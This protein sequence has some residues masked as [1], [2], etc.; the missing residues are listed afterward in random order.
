MRLP[1]P[2]ARS[3][4]FA[5]VCAPGR[6]FPAFTYQ[7]TVGEYYVMNCFD[8]RSALKSLWCPLAL[9]ALLLVPPAHAQKPNILTWGENMSS[10]KTTLGVTQMRESCT[11]APSECEPYLEN[12]GAE[13]SSAGYYYVSF[14]MDPSTSI[15]YA[16]DWSKLSLTYKHMVEIDFDD[17][18]GKLED[19]EIANPDS[20]MASVLAATKKYN[21][22]LAFGVTLYED[23]LLSTSYSYPTLIKLSATTRAK[24]GYVHLFIHYRENA[25]NWS[26]YVSQAK[27]LFPNAKIIA[28]AYPY[29][30]I[31]Y[32]PCAYKTTTKC[33]A[34][35]EQSYFKEALQN[36]AA[37]FKAGQ[38]SGIEF[39][40]GYFGM[41]ADWPGWT[42]TNACTSRSYTTCAANT[43]TLQSIAADV[44][45]SSFSSSS[46][47][48]GSLSFHYQTL[49]FGSETVGKTTKATYVTVTNG[50]SSSVTLHSLTLGGADPSDFSRSDDCPTTLG[51]GSSCYLVFYF[52]PKATGTRTANFTLPSSAGTYTYAIVGTGTN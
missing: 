34:S 46:S 42:S 23:N 17:F 8:F 26:T 31:D 7:T 38:I 37:S 3:Q 50:G 47:S 1:S 33:T 45:K 18:I 13:Q 44:L 4:N 39:Y 48:S 51:A 43:A 28:G 19:Y 21:S 24:I 16:E 14:S 9:A 49:N 36:Q 20:F 27:S 22:N 6:P 52:S 10:W 12:L 5:F 30:R 2:L 32:I 11:Y 25:A 41:P 40:F 35:Q 15:T 29:D